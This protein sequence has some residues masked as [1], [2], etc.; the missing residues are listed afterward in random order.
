MN[1]FKTIEINEKR[2]KNVDSKILENPV[3][4]KFKAYDNRVWT[5]SEEGMEKWAKK[6]F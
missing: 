3:N 1:R 5:Y 4:Q 6:Q 2:I